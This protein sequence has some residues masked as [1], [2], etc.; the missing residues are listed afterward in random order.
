[1]QEQQW[2]REAAE[3]AKEKALAATNAN[4][5]RDTAARRKQA[6]EALAERER[7]LDRRRRAFDASDSDDGSEEDSTTAARRKAVLEQTTPM[8]IRNEAWGGD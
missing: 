7:K 1:L 4:K 3:K 5:P 2:A 6:Q 8:S